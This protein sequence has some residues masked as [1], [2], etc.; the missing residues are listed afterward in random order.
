MDWIVTRISSS[1]ELWIAWAVSVALASGV[2]GIAQYFSLMILVPPDKMK[3][4]PVPHPF[5]FIDPLAI[6][7]FLI[8]GWGWAKQ[9]RISSGDPLGDNRLYRFIY[10]LAAPIGN[11]ALAGII[12]TLYTTILPSTVF[13]LAITIN[14]YVAAANLVIPIPPFSL[15]KGLS[16]LAGITFSKAAELSIGLAFSLGALLAYMREPF[17]PYKTIQESGEFI[18]RLLI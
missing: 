16:A 6:P 15:G 10:C 18:L 4:E 2:Q 14:C 9:Y 13:R 12:A 8:T 5:Q 11:L 3:K 7:L 1:V 17:F